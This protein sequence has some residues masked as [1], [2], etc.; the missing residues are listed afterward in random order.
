MVTGCDNI[1]INC[2]EFYWNIIVPLDGLLITPVIGVLVK[3]LAE[4]ISL[5]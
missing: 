3:P 2:T 4:A 5:Y 1:I